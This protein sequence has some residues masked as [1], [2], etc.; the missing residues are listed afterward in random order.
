MVVASSRPP[1]AVAHALLLTIFTPLP[2]QPWPA[3]SGASAAYTNALTPDASFGSSYVPSQVT[4][5]LAS[6]PT[7]PLGGLTPE[8]S[9]LMAA[10]GPPPAVTTNHAPVPLQR[11]RR[12]RT[13]ST[14]A[15]PH[16]SRPISPR[17]SRP[18]SATPK[19]SLSKDG[20]PLPPA[21]SGAPR[22]RRT[23]SKGSREPSRA[24]ESCPPSLPETPAASGKPPLPRAV[25]PADH[26]AAP[27]SQA[28][29]TE[30][31]P[32][33]EPQPHTEI[34]TIFEESS[35]LTATTAVSGASERSI[36]SNGKSG[37]VVAMSETDSPIAEG[38]TPSPDQA[39]ASREVPEEGGS[40]LQPDEE[41][42]NSRT[43]VDTAPGA[44]EASAADDVCKTGSEKGA[45][46]K[47]GEEGSGSMIPA[48]CDV[49]AAPAGPAA[50]AVR[51]ETVPSSSNIG[52]SDQATG[53]ASEGE[54]SPDTVPATDSTEGLGATPPDKVR[55]ELSGK[56]EAA[57]HAQVRPPPPP[58]H[59]HTH[60][61]CLLLC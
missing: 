48:G 42:A 31:P 55:V 36:K 6:A 22:P 56:Q 59:T 28:G 54:G 57:K 10:A 60:L 19:R 38:T 33:P 13:S 32:Q 45:V 24:G 9:G 8:T 29:L 50:G 39:T 17:G 14:G 41:T 26:D 23:S 58:P 46:D 61:C 52:N 21:A 35:R 40:S 5:P 51:G 7:T 20:V 4:I 30:G 15:S 44:V 37:G 27:V 49:A 34:H 47:D 16:P 12:T 18:A 11:P 2:L 25:E 43:A 53:Q 3:Q 1:L